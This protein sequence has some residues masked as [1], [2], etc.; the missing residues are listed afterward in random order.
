M[1]ELPPGY[2]FKITCNFFHIKKDTHFLLNKA[3]RTALWK[4]RSE[5]I[6]YAQE[7]YRR[8]LKYDEVVP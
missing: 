3:R 6:A 8:D 2:T 4:D 5:A 7:H 1:A